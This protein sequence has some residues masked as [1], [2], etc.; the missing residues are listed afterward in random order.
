MFGGIREKILHPPKYLR[1][2]TR[3]AEPEP[4]IFSVEPELLLKFIRIRSCFQ[5]L[6]EPELVVNSAAPAPDLFCAL[7]VG[8]VLSCCTT[9]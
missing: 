2:S 7:T 6:A 1:A 4:A 3:A 9:N 8:M 5:N